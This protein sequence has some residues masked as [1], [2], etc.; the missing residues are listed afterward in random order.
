MHRF[1]C[2]I[3]IGHDG[4]L[5]DG[6]FPE[7]TVFEAFR[8]ILENEAIAKSA[9]N[10]KNQILIL[11]DH[12]I[13]LKGGKYDPMVIS[14]VLNPTRHAHTHADL[15]KE[16]MQ[17]QMKASKDFAGGRAETNAVSGDGYTIVLRVRF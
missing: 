3:P 2:Y 4:L 11:S 17:Y 1:G 15:A 8:P 14:Y 9:Y 12:G 7:K 10:L 16:Y 5:N 13:Q 6:Q